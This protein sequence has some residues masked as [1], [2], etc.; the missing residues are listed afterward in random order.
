MAAVLDDS[1]EADFGLAIER[2]GRAT[3]LVFCRDNADDRTNEGSGDAIDSGFA[4]VNRVPNSSN[5]P[6]IQIPSAI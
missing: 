2:V 3:G 4:T 6:Q 1:F 5:S